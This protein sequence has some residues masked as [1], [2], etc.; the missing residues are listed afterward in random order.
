LLNMRARVYDPELGQFTSSDPLGLAGGDTNLRRYVGNRPISSADPSGLWSRTPV[1]DQYD[2][3]FG[4][5]ILGTALGY[6][7]VYIQR[8]ND[9]IDN[10][11]NTLAVNGGN[12]G[13]ASIHIQEAIAKDEGLL[14]EVGLLAGAVA[15]GGRAG[16]GAGNARA[17]ARAGL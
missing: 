12:P 2:A 13:P 8:L 15:A 10:L 17:G 11:N 4:A 1:G 5:V 7:P 16:P 6:G 9:E 3:D 14:Q